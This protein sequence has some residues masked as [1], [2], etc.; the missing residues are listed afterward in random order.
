[1]VDEPIFYPRI[2]RDYVECSSWRQKASEQVATLRPDFVILGSVQTANF[3]QAQWTEG[4]A[5]LLKVISPATSHVY[6]IRGT[7][8]LPFDGPGCLSSSDWLPWLRRLNKAC[9]APAFSKLDNDVYKWL[10]SAAKR[11]PNV[12]TLDLNSAICPHGQCSAERNGMVVFRDSQHLTAT[13]A[14]SLGET[15]RDRLNRPKHKH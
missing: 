14:R 2:G 7:P 11:F 6:L 8:H 9:R 4:T 13:F 3:D 10:Q 15:L 1:M 5:R 12:S